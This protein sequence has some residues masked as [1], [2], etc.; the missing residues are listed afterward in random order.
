MPVEVRFINP[1]SIPRQTHSHNYVMRPPE[2]RT[3][4]ALNINM[5]ER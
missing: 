3:Y 5:N 1:K 4:D 2:N